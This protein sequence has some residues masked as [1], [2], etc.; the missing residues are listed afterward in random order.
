MGH[1]FRVLA[2]ITLVTVLGACGGSGSDSASGTAI[3]IDG[4]QIPAKTVVDQ[5]KTIA[6]NSRFAKIL[7]GDDTTLVPKSG[8]IDPV[9]ANAW[10]TNLV[11][12]AIVDRAFA[13]RKLKVTAAQQRAAEK[14]AET[15]FR[16]KQSFDAFPASFRNLVVDGQARQIAL[17]ASFPK[18][19]PTEAE[20]QSLY[21]QVQQTCQ[22]DKL[23]S[24]IVVNTEAEAQ[25]IESELR[26]GA[27]FATLAK[28]RSTDTSASIG[29]VAM[30]IGSQ[31]FNS[32]VAAIQQA[33]RD[34]PIGATSAPIAAAGSYFILRN[35][36]LTYENARP[37]L[38]SDWH[39]QHPSALYDYLKNVRDHGTIKIAK[40]YG[41]L[42]RGGD[43]SLVIQPPLS[44]VPL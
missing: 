40:P 36:P 20:L 3:T 1:R 34:T 12:Q 33:V 5:L 23:V 22:N 6:A 9:V 44:P 16:G 32:T 8:T 24:Q 2:L 25:Q 37:L 13:Q 17:G 38:A 28:Q 15:L 26:Q 30:C 31:R 14:Q 21:T 27:D 42:V 19:E 29:G 7:K 41:I 43:G 4:T 35:L 18:H 39:G 10:V 11:N